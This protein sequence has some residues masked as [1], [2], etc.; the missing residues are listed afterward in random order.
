MRTPHR[1]SVMDAFSE[2]ADVGRR[3]AALGP[4]PWRFGRD[5]DI[6]LLEYLQ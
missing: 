4:L 1:L 3:V 5:G 6:D 2:A